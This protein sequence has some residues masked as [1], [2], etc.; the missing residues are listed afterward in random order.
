MENPS[1]NIPVIDER[2]ESFAG[3]N[4][5]YNNGHLIFGSTHSFIEESGERKDLVNEFSLNSKAAELVDT[6]FSDVGTGTNG[7]KRITLQLEEDKLDDDGYLKELKENS[8]QEQDVAEV[9]AAKEETI[10]AEPGDPVTI[11]TISDT[12]K[13]E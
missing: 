1:P 5:P 8:K 4:I 10:T 2:L 13:H 7:L 6:Q 11:P 3:E 9:E 12:I